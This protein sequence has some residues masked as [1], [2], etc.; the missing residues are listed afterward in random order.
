MADLL[1]DQVLAGVQLAKGELVVVFVIEHVHQV[2]EEG[3]DF[4]RER[5]KMAEN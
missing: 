3:M 1:V 5:K 4:L 2:G